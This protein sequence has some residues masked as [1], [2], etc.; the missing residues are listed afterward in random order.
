MLESTPISKGLIMLL[1]G[2]NKLNNMQTDSSVSAM[3]PPPPL[4]HTQAD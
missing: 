4:T 2:T 3:T 1:N